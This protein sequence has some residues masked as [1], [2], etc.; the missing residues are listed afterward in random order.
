MSHRLHCHR[1]AAS[2]LLVLTFVSGALPAAAQGDPPPKRRVL[3]LIQGGKH[4][5]PIEQFRLALADPCPSFHLHAATGITVTALDGA[6]IVDPN[7]NGCGYATLLVASA[8]VVEVYDSPLQDSDGDGL[9]D[10]AEANDTNPDAD[11]DG[12]LDGNE[13]GDQDGMG[14]AEELWNGLNSSNPDSDGDGIKDGIDYQ[15][16]RALPEFTIIP[17]IANIYQGSGANEQQA[18]D[19][20]EKANELFARLLKIRLVLVDVRTGQTG[21]DDGED[22]GS[23]AGDGR[24]G[25]IEG[26][27]VVRFGSQELAAKFPG[28]KG[29]KLSFAQPGGVD[30]GTNTPGIGFHREPTCLISLR[31]SIE[32]TATTIVHELLHIMTLSHPENFSDEDTPSNVMM[33]SPVRDPFTTSS[34]PAEGFENLTLTPGQ[35]ATVLRDGIPAQRGGTGGFRSPAAKRPYQGGSATDDG[36]D[37]IGAARHLDLGHVSLASFADEDTIHLLLAVEGTFP[38][39]GAIDVAYRL[40]FDRDANTAT[41]STVLTVPGIDRTLDISVQRASGS[42]PPTLSAVIGPPSPASARTPLASPS[43]HF[44]TK[45]YDLPLADVVIGELFEMR[46]P[47]A[48]LGFTAPLVPMTIAAVTP[49]PEGSGPVTVAD[50]LALD[51]DTELWTQFGDF[52][53]AQQAA[54]P[55]DSVPFA[56]AGLPQNASIAV[57]FNA[58]PLAPVATDGAGEYTGS[59]VVPPNAPEGVQFLTALAASGAFAASAIEVPEP[60]AALGGCIAFALLAALRAARPPVRARRRRTCA[61]R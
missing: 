17:L 44:V 2:T 16:T 5:V 49:S 31:A 45:R 53:I 30:V 29:M 14:A 22:Q 58:T 41:G 13:D 1:L 59:F 10:E 19:A 48:L 18:R 3:P 60:G 28:G 52:A 35:I 57:S 25:P 26:T 38:A 54:N 42:A 9:P 8:F 56:L 32:L 7:Q 47:R 20:V 51:F 46:I 4:L 40:L 23:I 27:N 37:Q 34:D 36:N 43:L 55:G 21:G 61:A 11:N 39:S 15:L 50:T 6:M 12:T 33:P 24:F